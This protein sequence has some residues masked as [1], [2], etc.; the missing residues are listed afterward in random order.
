ML[1]GFENFFTKTTTQENMA[2]EIPT[3]S[4]SAEQL[5][6]AAEIKDKIEELNAELDTI[7]SGKGSSEAAKPKSSNGRRKKTGRKASKSKSRS[8][9]KG[10]KRPVSPTGPLGPA[11]IKVLRRASEPMSVADIH[12]G[13]NEDGYVFTAADPRKNLYARIHG[14]KGVKRVAP[15]RFAVNEDEVEDADSES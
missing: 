7:L 13:L 5:R 6:R 10:R 11:V 2:V 12:E 4:I 14:L 9:L 8:P 15:G 1:R 3:E